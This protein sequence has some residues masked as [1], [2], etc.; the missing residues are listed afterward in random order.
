MSLEDLLERLKGRVALVFPGQ[1]SQYVGMGER[2]YEASQAAR[3]IFD[4]ADER[5]GR[6]LSRLIFRGP[7]DA[8]NDTANTQ[9]AVFTVSVAYLEGLKERLEGLGARLGEV[10][11]A[12]HSLGEFAAAVA[13][14]ALSFR[15]GLELVRR[16]GELMQR[17]GKERPGGMAAIIG[18]PVEEVRL[19]CRIASAYGVVVAANENAPDQVVLSGEEEALEVAVALARER[20]A[21]RVIPLKVTIPAHS[22]LMRQAAIQFSA[23]LLRASVR[24][25]RAP[26]VAARTG[27]ILRRAEEVRRELAAQLTGPVRW[28]EAV[29]TLKAEGVEQILEVGPGRVLSRLVRRIDRTLPA[30]S[31]DDLWEEL[32]GK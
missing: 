7:A 20:G 30:A 8:L 12:G 19:I 21:R 29:K 14:G 27:Q 16:R 24:E 28:V 32:E 5:L 3:R 1:G 25:P 13:S 22:P 18:L 2:L 6:R 31:L 4:E 26:M 23:A 15:E 11:V 10:R 9:P 17:A